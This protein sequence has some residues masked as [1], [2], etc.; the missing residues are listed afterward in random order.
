MSGY[1][2]PTWRDWAITLGVVAAA[3][4]AIV[5]LARRLGSAHPLVFLTGI[6]ALLF[7]LVSWHAARSAYRCPRC[8]AEFRLNAWQDFCS[9]NMVTSKYVCCPRCGKRSVMEVL[10]R[11]GHDGTN[12]S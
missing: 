7:A 9:P 2:T 4:G 3:V 8:G 12:I 10:T 6:A 11:S 1:S 5:V